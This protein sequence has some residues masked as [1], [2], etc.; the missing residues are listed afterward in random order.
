MRIR[1]GAR[2]SRLAVLGYISL[3]SETPIS[4]KSKQQQSVALFSAEAEYMSA[5]D[6][7]KEVI[8]LRSLLRHMGF[9]QDAPTT[10]YGDNTACI[11][12]GNNI[13]G[14]RE[15]A[16]HIDIRKHFAHEAIK[17][18]HM[19]LVKI[20]TTSQLAD[21]MTNGGQAPPVGD[22]QQGPT[23][24]TAE[25]LHGSRG[26]GGGWTTNGTFSNISREY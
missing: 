12:W 17:N 20:A 21:I 3:Y 2:R 19:V 25:V 7:A 9:G 18:G 15:R 1:T 13:I 22:V 11:E 8:Y 23:R 10:V 6:Y 5:S 14:G 16:K 4:W 26:S 24:T